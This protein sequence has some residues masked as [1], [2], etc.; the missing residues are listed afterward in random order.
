MIVMRLVDKIFTLGVTIVVI[1][2]AGIM[3]KIID[4]RNAVN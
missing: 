4:A 3:M 1:L 2:S